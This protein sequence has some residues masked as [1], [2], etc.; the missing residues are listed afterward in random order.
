M[1]R[2]QEIYG[3]KHFLTRNAQEEY[4]R[5]RQQETTNSALP[6]HEQIRSFGLKLHRTETHLSHHMAKVSKAE[7]AHREAAALLEELA[8]TTTYLTEKIHTINT[9]KDL[10]VGSYSP[11]DTHGKNQT[12]D[13]G[14]HEL[15]AFLDKARETEDPK[16]IQWICAEVVELTRQIHMGNQISDS[17]DLAGWADIASYGPSFFSGAHGPSREAKA[18]AK[19][20]A[21]NAQAQHQQS[22][23]ELAAAQTDS[24]AAKHAYVLATNLAA[25]TPDDPSLLEAKNNAAQ[26][27]AQADSAELWALD[28]EAQ[29]QLYLESLPTERPG[30]YGR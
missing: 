30:P 2:V 11:E 5:I 26:T 17:S 29:A 18:I 8:I 6:F 14:L 3:N 21:V 7:A 24:L 28:K 25:E 10:L 16:T 9:Q 13:T 1:Q 15:M 23:Y 12:T 4:Q 22:L 27:A 20:T 19:T